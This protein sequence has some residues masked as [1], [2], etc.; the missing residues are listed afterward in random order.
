MMHGFYFKSANWDGKDEADLG[1]CTTAAE[2][3]FRVSGA[4]SL[5]LSVCS[6]ERIAFQFEETS[7]LN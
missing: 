4:T 2:G 3:K 5:L 7:C 6:G 1:E